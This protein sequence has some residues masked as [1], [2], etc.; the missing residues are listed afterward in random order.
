MVTRLQRLRDFVDAALNEEDALQAN[1]SAANA[2]LMLIQYGL[3]TAIQLAL[4]AASGNLNALETLETS[5]SSLLRVGK[6]VERCTQLGSRLAPPMLAGGPGPAQ[7]D[8]PRAD[9]QRRRVPLGFDSGTTCKIA[10]SEI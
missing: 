8:R 7:T 9:S 10:E 6:Q 5:M 1:L 3:A 4:E 2:D